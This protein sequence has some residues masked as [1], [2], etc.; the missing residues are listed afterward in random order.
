[1]NTLAGRLIGIA[2]CGAL[3]ALAGWGLVVV[4][5]LEGV[6]GALAAAGVGM[7]TATAGFVGWTT[8]GARATRAK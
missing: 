4:A 5:A 2:L 3:G 6:L 8:L 7:V 1:M